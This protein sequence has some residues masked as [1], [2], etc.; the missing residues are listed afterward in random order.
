MS[1][2]NVET[3]RHIYDA[4]LRGDPDGAFAHIDEDVEWDA[5]HHPDGRV[6]HGHA[7][8]LE[9]IRGWLALWDSTSVQPEAFVD[10]GD[11]VVVLT[12]ETT[13]VGGA[14]VTEHHAELY[15]LRDGKVINWRAFTDQSEALKAAGVGE[16]A[17]AAG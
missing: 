14:E 3:V 7:G 2:R 17:S 15:T 13:S 12:T 16:S 10:A 9:F 4:Y 11:K 1:E 5:R 8:V 6:Y